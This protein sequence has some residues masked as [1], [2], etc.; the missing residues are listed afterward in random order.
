MT[1]I[2]SVKSMDESQVKIDKIDS[3]I[4]KMLLKDARTS[5]V[6]IAQ[7][8]GVTT[9]T[10]VKRF[11]KLQKNG[12]IIGTATQV[13]LKAFGI[14]FPLS[15]DITVE[16]DQFLQLMKSLK[17][18]PRFR[19]CYRVVGKYDIHALFYV[20][21]FEEIEQIRNLIKKNNGV[22][23]VGV[24]ATLDPYGFFPENL[25]IESTETKKNG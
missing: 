8:C 13:N 25:S 16:G 24:T 6:Q 2:S 3:N 22:K 20:R 21:A 4:L 9:N 18:I 15:V 11:K 17:R 5:F 12:V 10:I 7:S 19:S 23:R 14:H 1:N